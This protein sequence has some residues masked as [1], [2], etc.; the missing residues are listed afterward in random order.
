MNNFSRVIAAWLQ[1]TAVSLPII[2]EDAVLPLDSMITMV[3]CV[4]V[5]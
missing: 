4:G 5:N 1:C 3:P 2:I